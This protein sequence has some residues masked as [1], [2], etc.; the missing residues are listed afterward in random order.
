MKSGFAFAFKVLLAAAVLL[1][2]GALAYNIIA[3][4][5]IDG[6]GPA[7]LLGI[8]AVEEFT[9]A[10][11]TYVQDVDIEVD[12]NFLPSFVSGERV[13]ALVTGSVRATVDF[14]GLAEDSITVDEESNTIRI[15]IPEPTLSDADIDEKSVRFLDRERGFT[16]R[17]ADVFATNPTDDSP[18]FVKAEARISEAAVESDLLERGR[19]NTEQWL[20]S[21]LTA[22]GF[23]NVIINWQ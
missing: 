9:A 1:I 19:A 21:F 16:D 23:E 11:G 6:S 17:I 15:T 20:R 10:E 5:T 18:V 12:P 3:C 7:I 8:R 14:S 4:T 13:I 2:A 22:A